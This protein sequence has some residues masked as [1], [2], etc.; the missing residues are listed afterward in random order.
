MKLGVNSVL[1]GGHDLETAFQYIALAGYDG[2]ELSAIE[3]MSEHLD[4]E[5]WQEIAP[6]IKRLAKEY[7]LELLA[8]EQPSQDPAHGEGL[9]GRG[10][11]RHP[12]HQLR[13]RRQDR[14]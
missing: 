7:D 5:R 11:D 12:D 2:I 13:P 10:R 4:L 6:E 3:G 14:R 1:F 8:M 9:P